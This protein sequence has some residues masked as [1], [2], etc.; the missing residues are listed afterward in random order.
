MK[1]Q[2]DGMWLIII[3]LTVSSHSWNC[4][5]MSSQDDPQAPHC[6]CRWPAPYTSQL[7]GS[8]VCM[9][10]Y[11]RFVQLQ[12]VIWGLL[13]NS[14]TLVLLTLVKLPKTRLLAD[15]DGSKCKKTQWNIWICISATEINSQETVFN[16]I[17]LFNPKLDP[18][19]IC[20]D[21]Q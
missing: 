9:Q 3:V 17:K 6:C 12:N 11:N 8:A 2:S 10:C 14:L 1:K 20:H 16:D 4:W 19:C 7:T 5:K 21:V 15:Y 18:I 13:G